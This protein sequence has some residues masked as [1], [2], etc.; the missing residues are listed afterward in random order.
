[1]DT[2][3]DLLTDRTTRIAVVGASDSPGKYGGRVYR[4]LKSKGFDVRPV[5]PSAET[6]DG[7]PAYSTLDAIGDTP[8]ITVVVVPAAAGRSALDAAADPGFVWLQPGVADD[9]LLAYL[10]GRGLRHR[11]GECIMVATA[12]M[13]RVDR[14]H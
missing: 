4:N 12:G 5:H 14:E 1:M 10:D 2:I 8:N 13:G 3:D 7:D 9:D 6:V 11:A